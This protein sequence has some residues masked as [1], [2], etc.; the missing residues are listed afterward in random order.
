M[1]TPQAAPKKIDSHT[2]LNKQ[3]CECDKRISEY[4]KAIEKLNKEIALLR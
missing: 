2:E 4:T 3:I 1:D